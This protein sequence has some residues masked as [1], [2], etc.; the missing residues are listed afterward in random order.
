[1]LRTALRR[2]SE[3]AWSKPSATL[4]GSLLSAARGGQLDE[5]LQ[6]EWYQM[7]HSATEY[8]FVIR[9]VFEIKGQPELAAFD[10]LKF[11]GP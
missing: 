11:E 8:K 5:H 1:M 3:Q 2:R 7:T 10:R 4:C 9:H 6:D